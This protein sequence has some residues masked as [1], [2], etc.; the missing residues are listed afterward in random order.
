MDST[1]LI[2]FL[3]VVAFL[4][5]LGILGRGWGGMIAV[6]MVFIGVS[7]FLLLCEVALLSTGR[8]HW[9]NSKDGL[10]LISTVFVLSIAIAKALSKRF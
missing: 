1:F 4:G 2:P 10:I 6:F 5:L 8:M 9:S 7:G 3:A